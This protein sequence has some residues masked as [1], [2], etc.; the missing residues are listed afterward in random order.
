MYG[1]P[2]V[3]E[4]GTS[5]AVVLLVHNLRSQDAVLAALAPDLARALAQAVRAL[6][7]IEQMP[8]PNSESLYALK[9]RKALAAIAPLAERLSKG[10]TK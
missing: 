3:R 6:A 5:E 10:E 4:E 7:E 9:A 8:W 2:V 1:W